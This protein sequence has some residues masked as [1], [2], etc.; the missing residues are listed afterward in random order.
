MHLQ[1]IRGQIAKNQYLWSMHADEERRNDDLEI[2]EVEAAIMNGEILESYPKDPRGTSCLIYG[3]ANGTPVH[4]VCGKNKLEQL[5]I[6]TVYK[7]SLPK[8]K[9]PTERSKK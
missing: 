7:P 8:W 2:A 5:V 6:V 9:N 3:E 1:W 4:I